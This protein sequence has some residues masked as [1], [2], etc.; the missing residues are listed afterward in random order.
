M[1]IALITGIAALANIGVYLA[2]RS[3]DII[4]HEMNALVF[5]A[6]LTLTLCLGFSAT[7]NEAAD[8]H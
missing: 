7:V 8:N 6:T 5:W 3:L 4:P 2:V 1:K